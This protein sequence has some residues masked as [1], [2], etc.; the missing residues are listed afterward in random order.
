MNVS[1]RNVPDSTD[2]LLGHATDHFVYAQ[3]P[4][5]AQ[6]PESGS[7][8]P[9]VS[10]YGASQSR[11]NNPSYSSGSE[12]LDPKANQTPA[13]DLS[14]NKNNS[15]SS[16][17]F[18]RSSPGSGVTFSTTPTG[19]SSRTVVKTVGT[20]QPH[21]HILGIG[22]SRGPFPPD[23]ALPHVILRVQVISCHN[24]EPRDSSGHIDPCVLL[25][26]LLAPLY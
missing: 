12:G 25:I 4:D 5:S 23:K 7:I 17:S 24:L 22:S 1:R 18:F 26:I 15:E 2:T 10:F 9:Q 19:S 21:A 16:D 20:A 11:E 14:L 6:Q 13:D 8:H 3:Q